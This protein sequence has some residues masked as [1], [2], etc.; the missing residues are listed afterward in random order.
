MSECVYT[1]Q[2]QRAHW[3][4]HS[5][6][7]KQRIY[8]AVVGFSDVERHALNTIFRLSEDRE[9][10]YAP[11][12]PLTAPGAPPANFTAEVALVD[13]ESAEAVLAHARVTPPGQRLIWI[14]QDAPA[15]A[16]RVLERPIQWAEVLHDLDAV[17][18][19]RQADSGFLD[20][21]VT[22]PAPLESGFQS[23][24]VLSRRALLVGL[25]LADRETLRLRLEQ[26]DVLDVDMVNSTEAAL[27]QIGR[28]RYVCGVFN[29]D[30]HQLDGWSLA[31]HF[32]ERHPH[33]LN[34][35]VSE[36]AGPLAAWWS[37]RRIQRDRQ[38]AGIH[39]L[40]SRPVPARELHPWLGRL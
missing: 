30:D 18:A 39:A 20:L 26:R 36:H 11:W 16:W 38:R 17:Y 6:M 21:D 28:N 15:H 35:G 10:S 12:T 4:Y 19:A 7:S 32:G 24:P 23:M 3:A 22:A 40:L 1:K 31:R 34:M 8:V 25:D 13:G 33:A 2:V 37:R 9:L 27:E 5:R 14:G 29:L